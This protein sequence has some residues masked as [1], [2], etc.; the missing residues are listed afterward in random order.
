[1]MP[2]LLIFAILALGAKVFDERC[3]RQDQDDDDQQ[4]D[5]PHGPHHSRHHTV[6]HHGSS[7]LAGFGISLDFLNG[8][9][10]QVAPWCRDQ[11]APTAIVADLTMLG[12]EAATPYAATPF[13]GLTCECR[14]SC[15]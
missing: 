6:H 15:T 1:M 11:D 4:P 7:L 13:L 10:G 5:Q 14:A 2:Y 12:T 9:K 8:S 3:Y